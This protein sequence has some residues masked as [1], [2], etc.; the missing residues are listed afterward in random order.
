LLTIPCKG[1]DNSFEKNI[2]SFLLQNYS[3]FIINFVVESDRDPAYQKLNQ[4]KS[5]YAQISKATEINILAAGITTKCS[6]KIHNLLYSY[7]NCPCDIEVLAFAD[8]DICVHTDWLEDMVCLLNQKKTGATTG[9]RWFVPEKNNLASVS[10]SIA[11]AKITHLLGIY[12]FN[13]VWGGSMAILKK[14]FESFGIPQIWP[15]VVS[16]DYSLTYA[17]KKAGRKVV[18]IP[19]AIVAS[20]EKITW[21]NLFE[22]AR[23]Q[24]LITRVFMP[25]AWIFALISSLYAVIG[26]FGSLAIAIYSIVA[27]LPNRGFY[28]AVPIIFVFC[29]FVNSLLR[30]FIIKKRLKENFKKMRTTIVADFLTSPF[31][32]IVLLICVLSSA[33]GRVINWRGV[34]YKLVSPAKTI[35]L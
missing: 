3:D 24:F 23:R 32:T 5:Q 10:L 28:L 25:S 7:D 34:R 12:R 8:S 2:V 18:F 9:Y 29:Q 31:Y 1:I 33:F 13:Q 27:G 11:N 6:Q 21:R 4:L 15:D 20:Y 26:L 35:V 22:F 14:N 16:D 30:F 17:V 19:S